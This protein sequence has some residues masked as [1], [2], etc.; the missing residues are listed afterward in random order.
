MEVESTGHQS[1]HL[2]LFLECPQTS[3][4]SPGLQLSSLP[5]LR[6]QGCWTQVLHQ[7]NERG[8]EQL[9]AAPDRDNCSHYKELR[10]MLSPL[11]SWGAPC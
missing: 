5:Q 7:R 2:G 1:H 4:E 8:R 6:T 11:L 3:A 10:P 9:R